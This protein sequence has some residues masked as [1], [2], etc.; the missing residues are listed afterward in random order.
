MNHES[1]S[2]PF[3]NDIYIWK[4]NSPNL[5]NVSFLEAVE[6]YLKGTGGCA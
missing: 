1:E 3:S 5:N 6:H 2:D 4:V